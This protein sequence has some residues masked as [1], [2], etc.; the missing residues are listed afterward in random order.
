MAREQGL[1]GQFEADSATVRSIYDEWAPVYDGDLASWGYEAPTVAV[2][3]LAARTSQDDQIVDMGCGTGL[4]GVELAARGYHDVVGIDV[5]S[6]SLDIAA[7]STHYRAVAEHDLTSLP[8]GILDA[9]FGGL[10]CVGVMTYLPEVEA[11]CREF[12]RIVEPGGTI[13]VTQRSDLFVDRDTH[14][15][16]ERLERDGSWTIHEVTESRPYLPG[17]QEYQGIGVHYGVFGRR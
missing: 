3:L 14:A 12:C 11:T 5:S 15:A 13:V 2:G 8:T 9:T 7:E 6:E 1:A 10:I 4:V 16:F 17:H